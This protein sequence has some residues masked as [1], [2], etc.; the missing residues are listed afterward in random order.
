MLLVNELLDFKI[1]LIRK[2]KNV[3]YRV[4]STSYTSCIFNFIYDKSSRM[5]K[6]TPLKI[7]KFFRKWR[8]SILLAR[9]R[10]NTSI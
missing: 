10:A 6:S 4:F 8:F 2:T 5:I 1:S 7:K 3:T 9:E